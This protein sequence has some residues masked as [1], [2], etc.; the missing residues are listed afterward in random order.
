MKRDRTIDLHCIFIMFF[1]FVCIFCSIENAT[2]IHKLYSCS[3]SFSVFV[4]LFVASM[5]EGAISVT[6]DSI[7]PH[8][9]NF[10]AYRNA[11]TCRR[12]IRM[13]KKRK[14]ITSYFIA[15]CLCANTHSTTRKRFTI[16]II[17]CRKVERKCCRT[18]NEDCKMR[19][20]LFFS[21][22]IFSSAVLFSRMAENDA[23]WRFVIDCKLNV[24]CEIRNA[25]AYAHAYDVMS[26][27]FFCVFFF[28]FSIY[29]FFLWREKEKYAKLQWFI[30]HKWLTVKSMHA[31]L[32][33]AYSKRSTNKKKMK[34]KKKS[35]LHQM[36]IPNSFF[37]SFLAN[38]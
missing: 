25:Y 37:I 11:L 13:K 29:L 28:F 22:F 17:Q 4:I 32:R 38:Q 10:H 27:F 24:L 30:C 9:N 3:L 12:A 1:S 8:I 20:F 31:I 36:Q 26:M 34:K 18:K 6:F 21:F 33:C 35:N 15:F 23:W 16:K 2:N 7:K 19:K 5:V 14:Q